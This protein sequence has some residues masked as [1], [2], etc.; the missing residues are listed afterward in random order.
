MCSFGLDST[1][2]VL[3]I[4][5]N[6]QHRRD[7]AESGSSGAVKL[8]LKQ[9]LSEM[10]PRIRLNLAKPLPTISEAFEDMLEDITSSTKGFGNVYMSPDSCSGEDY[11]ESI[12][13]LARSSF[14]VPPENKHK[15]QDA[16]KRGMLHNSPK[17]LN[18]SETT[19][20]VPIYTLPNVMSLE[21][22]SFI[23][24]CFKTYSCP[25]VDPLEELYTEAQKTPQWRCHN[26]CETT[27]TESLKHHFHATSPFTVQEKTLEKQD[28]VSFFPRLPSQK[29]LQRGD[30]CPEFKILK[31]Q[32][33]MQTLA[34]SPNKKG[35]YFLSVSSKSAWLQLPTE[36]PL[37]SK[38]L[39]SSQNGQQAL[40]AAA[41]PEREQL[42]S[43][44]HSQK[45]KGEEN[46]REGHG[47]YFPLGQ[48][49]TTFDW[50]SEYQS[51]WKAAKVRAC[52]LPAIAES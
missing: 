22:N 4:K 30:S 43:F 31:N 36:T 14:P 15:V 13:Q 23:L 48:R 7:T 9:T 3:E 47:R 20:M 52:L 42:K 33:R 45:G 16:D 29:L 19:K 40:K 25:F 18:M 35:N 1:Y 2:S 32:G 44:K 17:I 28:A 27:G 11:L 12:C 10:A 5:E 24:D 37:G 6:R 51:A 41:F 21:R 38:V 34:N 49:V 8:Y 39:R 46:N 50:I 26:G